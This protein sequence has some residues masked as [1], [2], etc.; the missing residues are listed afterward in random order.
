MGGQKKVSIFEIFKFEFKFEHIACPQ[1]MVPRDKWP[2]CRIL[3]TGFCR[4]RVPT[5]DK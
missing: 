3:E 1:V 2:G 5:P 4:E